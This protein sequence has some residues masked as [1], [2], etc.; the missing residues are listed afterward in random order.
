[1][2]SEILGTVEA[3]RRTEA[4][5]M[6]HEQIALTLAARAA[7]KPRTTLAREKMNWLLESLLKTSSP[8]TCPHGHPTVLRLSTRDI[9]KGFHHG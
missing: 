4:R 8:T 6:L 5:T 7:I 1:M 9:E 3:A 2:L